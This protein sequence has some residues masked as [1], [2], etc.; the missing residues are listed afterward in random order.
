MGKPTVV[1]D[2]FDRWSGQAFDRY[3]KLMC[4]LKAE[5]LV[6]MDNMDPFTKRSVLRFMKGMHKGIYP[7]GKAWQRIQG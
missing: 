4:Q 5:P 6:A 3:R 7:R 1:D 2:L